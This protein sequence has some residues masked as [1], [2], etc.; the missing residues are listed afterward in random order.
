MGIEVLVIPGH[1]DAFKVTTPSDIVLAEAI[2]AR[3][4]A[5]GAVN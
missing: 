2:L 5:A 1:E 3:R 4:R